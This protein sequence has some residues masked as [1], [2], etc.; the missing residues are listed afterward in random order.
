MK[1]LILAFTCLFLTIPCWARVIIVKADGSG[2]YPTIQAAINNANNGDIIE[3]QPGTYIGPGNRN[4]DFLGKAITVRSIDPNDPCVVAATVIDCNG[5]SSEPHRGFHFHSGE[6]LNSVID[7]LTITN[8][9]GPEAPHGRIPQSSGGA[10]FCNASSPTITKC[11]IKGNSVGWCGGGIYCL[12]SSP[13]I[14]HCIIAG[15]SACLFGGGIECQKGNPT[16]A[17]CT[18]TGNLANEYGGIYRYGSSPTISHCILWANTAPQISSTISSESEVL[19]CDIEGGYT[20]VGNINA[21]PSFVD[22]ANDDYHLPYDS[23]C[24][25]AGDP[26]YSDTY[27]ETDIDGGPRVV[28]GRIDI[29]ADEFVSQGAF[30]NAEPD[31]LLITAVANEPN[32]QPQ[33]ISIGNAGPDIMTWEI[34]EDCPWL[35]VFPLTGICYEGADPCEVTLSFD[36]SGLGGGQHDCILTITSPEAENS[37]KQL[38]VILRVYSIVGQ[39]SVPAEYPTIQSAIDVAQDGDEVIIAPSIYSGNGNRDLD[40]HGKPITV[41]SIDPHDPSIVKATVID[42]GGSV[43]QS[44]RGFYFHSGED[45]NSTVSGLT[46]KNGYV[47]NCGAGIYCNSASPRIENCI[48]TENTAVGDYDE[49]GYGG[50]VACKSSNAEIINC[51]I[52]NNISMGGEGGMVYP[53]ASPG[54]NGCGGG[55]YISADSNAIIKNCTIY[56]NLA[57]GG[58][59]DDGDCVESTPANGGDGL[60]GGIYTE[61]LSGSIKNCLIYGNDCQGGPG[62]INICGSGFEGSCYGSGIYGPAIVSNSII[63]A[64]TGIDQIHG[65]ANITYS[66]VQGGFPG[67]GNLNTDPLFADRYNGD[68]HLKS[69]AGRWEL[70]SQSWVQDTVTSPCIDAGD[71]N[72]DWTAELWPHG[73]RINMGAYGGT[74]Q[75]SMSLSDAGNI[76]DLDNDDFVDYNDLKLY[77]EKWLNQQVLLPEDLNRNGFIDFVDFAIFANNW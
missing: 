52:N 31:P 10:I 64:N 57:K 61:S 24:V 65:S 25:N 14:S 50:A 18:I 69:Q 20:G 30:I 17:H 29:G 51:T 7:G 41:R 58:K 4:I 39:V 32:P 38:P 15:N 76:A 8:G 68:Y 60:G 49:N 45:P 63:W 11:R 12:N 36:I 47:Y 73:K 72:S 3:V 6:G 67:T 71:P 54:A 37:P 13:T 59:G 28:Y 16:I 56:N 1:K 44:H 2:D 66:D 33:I 53:V 70:S 46:I 27:G 22:P 34:S 40:F 43:S 48:I 35:E 42:C 55:I 21:D 19:Y 62:G 77:S 23:P 5:S 74:P 26:C 9:Y 75:A